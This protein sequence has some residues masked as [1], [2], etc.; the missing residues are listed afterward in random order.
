M[1]Y[2]TIEPGHCQDQSNVPVAVVPICHNLVNFPRQSH[3]PLQVS[4]NPVHP[5]VRLHYHDL[6]LLV[7]AFIYHLLVKLPYIESVNPMLG[8]EGVKVQHGCA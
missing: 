3:V 4:L 6:A 7:L 1:N 2:L 8:G 5:S